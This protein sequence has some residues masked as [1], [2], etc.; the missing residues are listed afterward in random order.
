MCRAFANAPTLTNSNCFPSPFARSM[1]G[2]VY[3]VRL[4]VLL[5]NLLAAAQA[6]G[7]AE[8]L[9]QTQEALEALLAEVLDDVL[10]ADEA[11]Q[12]RGE[13]VEAAA[14]AAAAGAGP[15]AAGFAGVRATVARLASF[16]YVGSESHAHLRERMR[17]ARACC[18]CVCA[19]ERLRERQ[20]ERLRANACV[21]ATMSRPHARAS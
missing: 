2:M 11:A 19:C 8:L 5:E 3:G 18:A 6:D 16:L 20:L 7:S 17:V 21:A 1:F 4:S 14:A 15:R 12:A 10:A 9:V 13:G